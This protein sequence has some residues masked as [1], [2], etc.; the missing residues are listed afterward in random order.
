MTGRL[1]RQANVMRLKRPDALA[2]RAAALLLAGSLAGCSFVESLDPTGLLSD[3]PPAPR[4][5]G[6]A[7]RVSGDQTTAAAGDQAYPKLSTVP[8]PPQ[9]RTA[10]SV[11][12]RV[13]EGLIADRENARYTDQAIRL[14]GTTPPTRTP[15]PPAVAP[16]P[17]V[18]AA[19]PAPPPVAT[20]PSRAPAPPPPAA[21]PPAP[22][23]PQ[24]AAVPSRP[25]PPL[26][27]L[28]RVD[29]SA[30]AAPPP[31]PPPRAPAP[32][33]GRQ[34]LADGAVVVDTSVLGPARTASPPPPAACRMPIRPGAPEQVA[35][36]QFG[37]NSSELD[38]RDRRILRQVASLQRE[39]GANVHVI[40]H[41][42]SRTRQ[43][44]IGRH[45]Q[46]NLAVS[47]RRANAVARALTQ[48]GVSAGAVTVEA[49]ADG[50]PQYSESMPNG[51][52]GN[53]RAEVFLVR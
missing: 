16:Q 10:P 12:R 18:T 38:G 28:P 26:P 35:I 33:R 45:Q 8:Q 20:A 23:P 40:G 34:V 41:A 32:P 14:Q 42:S 22:R 44:D 4:G 9:A 2:L 27:A 47:Q 53:R 39:T 13:T 51:E 52:A 15:P 17:P 6:E 49:R 29:A 3:D 19:R 31:P 24:T 21:L 1:T 11:R 50:N 43:L 46:V 37:L 7:T 36:I 25:A 30:R 5:E 48:L